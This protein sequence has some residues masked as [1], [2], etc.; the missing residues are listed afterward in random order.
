MGMSDFFEEIERR[1]AIQEKFKALT[2][3][4]RG[5]LM[6]KRN[7]LQKAV[8]DYYKLITVDF[9][10]INYDREAEITSFKALQKAYAEYEFL[11]EVYGLGLFDVANTSENIDS[12]FKDLVEVSMSLKEAGKHI[13]DIAKQLQTEY[14]LEG[15]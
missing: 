4:D 7:L 9:E 3:D 15:R 1:I 6:T 2:K 12:D 11:A 10:G 8:A 14:K 13:R 5:V